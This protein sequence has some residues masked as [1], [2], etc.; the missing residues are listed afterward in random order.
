VILANYVATNAI[1]QPSLGRPLAGNA[2]NVTV[3][4]VEPGEMYGERSTQM[5]V[6][7]S[8]IVRIRSTRT[9]A[10]LD[11]YNLFNANPV[12]TQSNAFA[13]WLRP[14]SIL[15]SRWAKVIFQ[16]DF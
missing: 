3:N 7:I 10:S 13:T 11:V 16:F 4:I 12:L 2:A 1:V 8:K 9:T 6:R 5:Q 14:T 15:N